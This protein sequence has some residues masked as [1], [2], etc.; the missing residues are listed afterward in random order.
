MAAVHWYSA[1]PATGTSTQWPLASLSRGTTRAAAADPAA[2]AMPTGDESE[3]T[4]GNTRI[5]LTVA[6][7]LLCAAHDRF[8]DRPTSASTTR[9]LDSSR[10]ESARKQCER[11]LRKLGKWPP[12]TVYMELSGCVCKHSKCKTL[13]LW[14][15]W[16]LQSSNL[17]KMK[18]IMRFENQQ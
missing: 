12:G 4:G 18:P 2:P 5:Q 3:P 15:S 17:F 11:D 14:H 13:R 1:S 6:G 7:G 9:G 10:G 16:P 8:A